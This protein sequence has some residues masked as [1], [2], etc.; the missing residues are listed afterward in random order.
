MKYLPCPAEQGIGVG[1]LLDAVIDLLREE[2][3]DL[4]QKDEVEKS[5]RVI[6]GD[7]WAAKCWQSL[8]F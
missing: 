5:K 8:H 6:T 7:H 3:T 2:L 4:D 1:E